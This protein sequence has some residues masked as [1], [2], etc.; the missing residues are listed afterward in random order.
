MDRLSWLRSLAALLTVTFMFNSV[1]FIFLW[2]LSEHS[3]LEFIVML[4]SLGRDAVRGLPWGVGVISA[5][6][7]GIY[8][9]VAVSEVTEQVPVFERRTLALAAQ[10]VVAGFS[11]SL[12]VTCFYLLANGHR[13]QFGL[14]LWVAPLTFLLFAT[15]TYVGRF[16]IFTP[17]EEL[18]SVKQ[19]IVRTKSRIRRMDRRIGHGMS[20]PRLRESLPIHVGAACIIGIA[21]VVV[22]SQ[23]PAAVVAGVYAVLVTV[24]I[25]GAR[26]EVI[27]MGG[28]WKFLRRKQLPPV[29][30]IGMS[31]ITILMVILDI[32]LVVVVFLNSGCVGGIF[33]GAV[34]LGLIISAV[35]VGS[36][37]GTPV[38]LLGDVLASSVR[39]E[40]LPLLKSHLRKKKLEHAHGSSDLAVVET[41]G[42]G[43]AFV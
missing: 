33:V 27:A 21:P 36:L 14:L 18:S 43:E 38:T 3:E 17:D 22:E 39:H 6:L 1:L 34:T 41:L 16:H 5:L 11:P 8:G 31:A 30:T 10:V 23:D 32:L 42:A 7:F 24:C 12:F 9:L 13:P 4:K 28:V 29:V 25:A 35:S 2:L 37:R 19:A 40:Q 20:S 15:A 26:S